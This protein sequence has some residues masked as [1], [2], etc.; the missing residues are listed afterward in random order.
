MKSKLVLFPMLLFYAGLI[1]C[2]DKKIEPVDYVNPYM[3]NI[4][5]LLVPTYPTV[6]LPNSMLR[7]YPNR[8]NYT[9]NQIQGFPLNVVSHRSGKVF[10]LSPFEEDIREINGNIS[11]TYDNEIVKPYYYSVS[12]DEYDIDVKFVPAEKSG[13]F[14]FHFNEGSDRGIILKTI[15]Q[16]ELSFENSSVAGY[17]TFDGVKAYLFLEFE[18]K[19]DYVKVRDRDG[20]S[21]NNSISGSRIALIAGFSNNNSEI[22][23]RYGLSY[24]SPEQ[25]QKNLQND[26]QGWD[27]NELSEKARAKWNTVLSKIKTEGGSENQRSVFYT[28]LYRCYERMVDITEDGQYFSIWSKKVEPADDTA[29]YTDDWVWDT[30]LAF[31]HLE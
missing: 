3:G 12:L 7:F 22:K 21:D 10:N 4:S 17:D 19:P 29:F 9:S 5:H 6:H 13:V 8:D 23:I 25:A 15:N 31:Q 30:H 14:S 1:S 27:V 11:Y 2:S 28:S 16:G 26:I 24:I 20:L 18:S